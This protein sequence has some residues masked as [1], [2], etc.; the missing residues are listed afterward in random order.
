[1]SAT[2]VRID[3]NAPVL[4]ERERRE[5]ERERRP[6]NAIRRSKCGSLNLHRV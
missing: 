1:M 3:F 2:I 4:T 6:V 5:A